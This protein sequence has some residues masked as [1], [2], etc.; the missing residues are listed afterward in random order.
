MLNLKTR[1]IWEK[2]KHTITIEMSWCNVLCR[3]GPSY[4]VNNFPGTVVDSG[5]KKFAHEII[6][7]YADLRKVFSC[8]ASFWIPLLKCLLIVAKEL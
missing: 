2:K 3:A 7:S 1:S 4:Y 6:S 8:K 5:F